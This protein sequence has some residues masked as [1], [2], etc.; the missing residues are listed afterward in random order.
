M[1]WGELTRI[2][3]ML[4]ALQIVDKLCTTTTQVR[5]TAS[6]S[7]PSCTRRSLIVSMLT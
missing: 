4:S 5:R 2:T 6:L 3:M 7:R 1:T